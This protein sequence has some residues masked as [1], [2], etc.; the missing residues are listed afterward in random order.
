MRAL[1]GKGKDWPQYIRDRYFKSVKA[2]DYTESS[3]LKFINETTTRI[4]KGVFA[5]FKTENLDGAPKEIQD[6]FNTHWAK[7]A[8]EA[9][10]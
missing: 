3:M 5:P 9:A 7:L 6:A 10:Q 1:D 4:G 8:A 2:Q